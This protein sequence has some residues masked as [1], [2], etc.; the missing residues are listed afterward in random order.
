MNNIQFSKT[1]YKAV[2]IKSHSGKILYI[3]TGGKKSGVHQNVN[4]GGSGSLAYFHG[5]CSYVACL[6]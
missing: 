1:G 5:A 2:C 3:F 6:V 4:S